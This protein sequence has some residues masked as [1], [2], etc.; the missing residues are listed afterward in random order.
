MTLKHKI[1]AYLIITAGKS[2]AL[3]KYKNLKHKI[4]KC[5]SSIYGFY[6]EF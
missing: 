5:N 4:L 6:F 1:N 2:G 3:Y